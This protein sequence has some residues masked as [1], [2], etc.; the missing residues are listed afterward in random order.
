MN[1]TILG[2]LSNCCTD[3]GLLQ[4][5][6]LS[7]CQAEEV[8]LAKQQKKGTA[9]YVGSY[10][11]EDIL[12]LCLKKTKSYCVFNSKLAR[13]IHQ[14]GRSQI[15]G[16]D[17]GSSA[18]A[19]CRGFTIKELKNLDFSKIDL[20]EFFTDADG[21]CKRVVDKN[22]QKDLK[23]KVSDYYKTKK[24]ASGGGSNR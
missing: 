14:Q 1:L 11:S 17:W 8:A 15:K 18:N 2:I 22:K 10:C 9:Y 12:G 3:D 21:K 13:I 24:K 20:S 19:N 23:K 5:I 4:Q 6:S 7:T 16:F